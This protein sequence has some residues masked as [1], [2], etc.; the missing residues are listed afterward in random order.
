MVM[1]KMKILCYIA[2]F[3]GLMMVYQHNPVYTIII[4]VIAIGLY[5]FYKA[6]KGNSGLLHNLMSGSAASSQNSIEDLITL[7][8]IQQMFNEQESPRRKD[9]RSNN[10]KKEE[11]DKL[12]KI[13]QEI[14]E[15]LSE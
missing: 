12:E 11:Q 1:E 10:K 8:V 4:I 14:L 2:L 9:Y 15:L 7:M 13:H 5:L 6:K 3:V